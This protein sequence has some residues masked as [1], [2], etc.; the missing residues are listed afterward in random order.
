[1]E[2]ASVAM[3]AAGV[4]LPFRVLAVFWRFYPFTCARLGTPISTNRG[5]PCGRIDVDGRMSPSKS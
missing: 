2:D 5:I 1:M 4:F 3:V